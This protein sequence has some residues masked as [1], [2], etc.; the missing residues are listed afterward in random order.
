MIP[1]T[2]SSGIIQV[3]RRS[4]GAVCGFIGLGK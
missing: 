3:N 4:V 1:E 2:K